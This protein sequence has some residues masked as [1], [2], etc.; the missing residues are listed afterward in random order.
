MF[1]PATDVSYPMVMVVMATVRSQKAA[2]ISPIS[3]IRSGWRRCIKPREVLSLQTISK[4]RGAGLK[5]IASASGLVLAAQL[6]GR[7]ARP[8]KTERTAR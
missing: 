4:F 3:P 1:M 7:G 2:P 8:C 5:P 6:F